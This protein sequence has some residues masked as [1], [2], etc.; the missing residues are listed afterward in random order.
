MSADRL[1][2]ATAVVA[3]AKPEAKALIAP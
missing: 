2:E 1:P 3:A